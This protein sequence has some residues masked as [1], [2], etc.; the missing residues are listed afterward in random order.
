ME[1]WFVIGV[2]FLV[3]RTYGTMCPLL[4]WVI[5]GTPSSPTRT[6]DVAVTVFVLG[7]ARA[8]FRI[9]L[10]S[11]L[12]PDV[13]YA[14]LDAFPMFSWWRYL[15]W[16]LV[17][18]TLV[19]GLVGL[20]RRVE[21]RLTTSEVRAIH[22]PSGTLAAWAGGAVQVML[23]AGIT[24]AMYGVDDGARAFFYLVGL[25]A[26]GVLLVLV[27]RSLMRA[28]LLGPPTARA[29]MLWLWLLFILTWCV[30]PVLFLVT[31]EGWGKL[32]TDASNLAYGVVDLFALDAL[33]VAIHVTTFQYVEHRDAVWPGLWE[34]VGVQTEAVA[35]D[36]EVVN[37]SGVDTSFKLSMRNPGS[38][39]AAA[40]GGATLVPVAYGA[41]ATLLPPPRDPSPLPP[42]VPSSPPPPPQPPAAPSPPPVPAP[43]VPAPVVLAPSTPP[44][45]ALLSPVPRLPLIRPPTPRDDVD[46]ITTMPASDEGHPFSP[47]TTGEAPVPSPAAPLPVTARSDDDEAAIRR[48]MVQVLRGRTAAGGGGASR[49]GVDGGVVS[50]FTERE[51]KEWSRRL[52]AAAAA[53]AAASTAR[54]AT[55]GTGTARA[56]HLVGATSGR[57]GYDPAMP[58]HKRLYNDALA[59]NARLDD[60]VRQAQAEAAA[61]TPY[62][63]ASTA[64]P[65]TARSR[66]D[67]ASDVSPVG[68][69]PLRSMTTKRSFART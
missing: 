53:A 16:L 45:P 21:A 39:L 27:S 48:E 2:Q 31:A 4:F 24:A 15:Q 25:V 26:G 1:T 38:P 44:P 46:G 43:V 22:L 67:A 8:T 68:L 11:Q 60:L 23:V 37:I 47:A 50:A 59:R 35:V 65:L 49:G 9:V 41:T 34:S 5:H 52:N 33:A 20:Q 10:P 55:P 14:N 28:A 6:H 3:Q 13:T 18:P 61:G 63:D 12:P 32:G 30:Y 57:I 17:C 58:V 69:P 42:S 51:L 29:P 40:D 36:D 62:T 66:G 56:A 19:A 54:S 64:L 7:D